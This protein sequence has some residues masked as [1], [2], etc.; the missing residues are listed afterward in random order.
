MSNIQPNI[1]DPGKG[2][3]MPPDSLPDEVPT[4]DLPDGDHV[5]SDEIREPGSDIP[6]IEPDPEEKRR[7]RDDIERA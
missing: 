5:G 6:P 2:V 7:D 1:I 4:E 3:P